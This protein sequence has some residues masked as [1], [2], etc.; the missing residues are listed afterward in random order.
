MS[1]KNQIV[2]V[3]GGSSGIGLATAKA[4]LEEGAQVVITGRSRDKLDAAKSQLGS[5]ARA[6]ALDAADEAGTRAL[7]EAMPHIDHVFITAGSVTFGAG[8]APETAKLRPAME[9]RFWG[10]LY[11]AKY[12]APKMSAGGSITFMSGTSHLKPI[13]GASI[14]SASCAA[15]EA[16]ARSLAIDLAPIRVNTIRPGFIDT[17]L[18]DGLLGEHRDAIVA[19]ESERLP[20]GRIGRADEVADAVLFL[21]KNGYVNGI[22]LT[23]DGGRLLT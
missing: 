22:V 15:V 17:P 16:F 20:V 5:E 19:R 11:A 12:A 8:L 14:G 21:M 13:A 1:L 10:A 2:V 9:T 3:L 7:L 23:V 6:V 18:I 4:A